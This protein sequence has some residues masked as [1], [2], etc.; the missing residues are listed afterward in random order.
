M[1]TCHSKNC[2]QENP[3]KL[4]NFH[5]STQHKDGLKTE[6][7]NCRSDYVK[8]YRLI[9]GDEMRQKNK[10]WEIKNPNKRRNS[11]YKGNYGITLDQYEEMVKIQ[12]GKCLLC[13]KVPKGRLCID[14][15]HKNGRIRGLLCRSC[16][17]ALGVL[18]ETLESIKKVE[19]Y[20]G[21]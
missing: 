8:K 5:R 20:L 16:N 12:E 7:R 1:K 18:G 10:E 9:H 21:V 11:M 4:S 2:K 6:C 14:H 13:D 3:Q 19:R 17:G 15:C